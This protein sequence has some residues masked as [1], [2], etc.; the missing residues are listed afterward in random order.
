MGDYFRQSPQSC[1]LIE[2]GCQNEIQWSVNFTLMNGQYHLL[3]FLLFLF[4]QDY[5]FLLKSIGRLKRRRN[6]SDF[7]K[8]DLKLYFLTY[9]TQ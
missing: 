5:L 2:I 3:Y 1:S 9:L 6:V 4:Q 8:G 7:M